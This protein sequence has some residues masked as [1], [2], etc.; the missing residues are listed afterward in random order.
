MTRWLKS[1]AVYTNF[2]KYEPQEI[3]RLTSYHISTQCASSTTQATTFLFKTW[4]FISSRPSLRNSASG[5]EKIIWMSPFNNFS[6]GLFDFNSAATVEF[7]LS[8]AGSS[9]SEQNRLSKPAEWSLT[10]CSISA[11]TPLSFKTF[12]WSS[13][14]EFKGHTTRTMFF[15]PLTGKKSRRS[16]NSSNFQNPVGRTAITSWQFN[17]CS[18]HF[19]WRG[20]KQKE[21]NLR[22]FRAKPSRLSTN[23]LWVLSAIVWCKLLLR[24]RAL[25]PF[26]ITCWFTRPNF[27]GCFT[28]HV[29][30]RCQGL[31]PPFLSSAE[32]SPG[33][34]VED[35]TLKGSSIGNSN[36]W[37][38]CIKIIYTYTFIM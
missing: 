20:F 22:R 12:N 9:F 29:I 27:S 26:I 5:C 32:K 25:F 18:K 19:T 1:V 16:W 4:V 11:E 13:I 33:N 35:Q 31:F 10:S 14:M 21:G 15:S 8:A 3:T 28:N 30:D 2:R 6:P 23:S 36:A 37:I 7:S 38:S 34:E 24:I 17:I